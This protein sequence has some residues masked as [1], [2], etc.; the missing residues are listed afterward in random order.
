MKRFK[1]RVRYWEIWNEPDHPNYWQPQDGLAAYA[2]LL[3]KATAAVKEEDP[4]ALTLLG[5]LSQNIPSHLQTIYERAGKNSFD[6]VN[7][8]PF[9]N[10][11]NDGALEFVESTYRESLTVMRRFDDGDKPIWLTEIGCPGLRGGNVAPWWLGANPTEEQQAQWLK[12]VFAHVPS[13]PNIER[14]FWAF[15]RD[16][17]GHFKDG[18]DYFGLVREDFSLK[19]AYRALQRASS[20]LNGDLLS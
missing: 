8:H 18:V 3:T 1:D 4:S 16:T 12:A 7:M 5:G 11:L 13:W 17:P 10:P 9:A 19:P 14:V 15:F 2:A 20:K 6:V